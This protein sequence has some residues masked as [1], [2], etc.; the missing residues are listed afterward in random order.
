MHA[1]T[2]S[3]RGDL[4]EWY[5]WKGG[6]DLAGD[7]GGAHAGHGALIAGDG[8]HGE[9][10]GSGDGV[11]AFA[12]DES[13]AD[14]DRAALLGPTLHGSLTAVA[15]AAAIPASAGDAA[16]AFVDVSPPGGG[17]GAG[18]LP[19]APRTTSGGANITRAALPH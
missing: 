19:L 11:A 3:F 2:F 8:A 13:A 16:A 5:R 10:G 1:L 14:R 17:A 18:A 6:D 4:A 15:A 7:G 9:G 12:S